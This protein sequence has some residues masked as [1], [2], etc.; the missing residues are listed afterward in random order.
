[1]SHRKTRDGSETPGSHAVP[2]AALADRHRRLFVTSAGVLSFGV[3]LGVWIAL[4]GQPDGQDLVAGS[5]AAALAVSIGFFVSRRGEA[6]PG[7]RRRD[8]REA[9]AL[10]GR[11][12][13]ETWQVFMVAARKLAGREVAAGRWVTV[14]AETGADLEGWRAARRDSVRTV[15]LS[16]APNTVVADIDAKAGTALVHRLAGRAGRGDHPAGRP[17][18]PSGGR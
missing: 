9:A 12:V 1:M 16:A 3:L 8:L 18:E 4:A 2:D 10:P 14:P 5:A 11:L 13:V 6:L 17:A 15:L 7:L